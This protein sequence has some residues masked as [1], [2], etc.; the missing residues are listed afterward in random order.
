ME[1]LIKAVFINRLAELITEEFNLIE[2]FFL[3]LGLMF[4]S[5]IFSVD[6]SH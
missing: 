1:V 5:L 6:L 2:D 3:S 4:S